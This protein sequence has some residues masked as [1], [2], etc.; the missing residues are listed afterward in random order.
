[1]QLAIDKTFR[2]YKVS[3]IRI[4]AQLY[5]ER[6]YSSLGFIK[7]SEEYLE[8]DIPHIEMLLTK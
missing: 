7:V 2:Q 3:A 6:F 1:M 8:D 5:L 4:G